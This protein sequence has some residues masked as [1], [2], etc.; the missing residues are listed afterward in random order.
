[1]TAK[2][3]RGRFYKTLR[4][5]SWARPYPRLAGRLL[6]IHLRLP[7][8]DRIGFHLPLEYEVIFQK[9]V[10]GKKNGHSLFPAPS[11]QIIEDGEHGVSGPGNGKIPVFH[12]RVLSHVNYQQ[13][14]FHGDLLHK[15][16]SVT[17]CSQ[18]LEVRCQ[19]RGLR[20]FRSFFRRDKVIPFARKISR[21]TAV[22]HTDLPIRH[23][24]YGSFRVPF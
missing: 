5:F 22:D 13:G 21:A 8:P 14:G 20:L 7:S 6:R 1:M 17:G 3:D 18:K 23:P 4:T 11:D 9:A 10:R 24:A 19:E 15:I 12:H 2:S 16:K